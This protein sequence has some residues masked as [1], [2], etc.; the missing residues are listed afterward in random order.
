MSDNTADK[1]K[2]KPRDPAP[3]WPW[4]RGFIVFYIA[5]KLTS[6]TVYGALAL[7]GGEYSPSSIAD[8]PITLGLLGLAFL[9]PL[10]YLLCI[11]LT[12]RVQYRAIK[13]LHI[14]ESPEVEM[15][16][17]FSVVSYF[18]PILNLGAPVAAVGQIWRGTFAAVAPE[19][20][21]PSGRLAWWW[22]AFLLSGIVG[23][24]GGA[25]MRGGRE[26]SDIINAAP[27][28]SASAL[29][30]AIAAILFWRVFSAIVKGQTQLVQIREF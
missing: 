11:I 16:P 14:I 2:G 17:L 3:L 6:V 1:P 19:R 24:V 9:T 30:S 8:L 15:G 7:R 18:I 22:A 27:L 12:L 26:V 21:D 10:S 28:V 29:L 23:G 20:I 5:M 25:V 4:L 13:N